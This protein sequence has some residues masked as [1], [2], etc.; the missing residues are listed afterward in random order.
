MMMVI[1]DDGG[2]LCPVAQ[3]SFSTVCHNSAIYRV[4]EGSRADS[5]AVAKEIK[6]SYL[7]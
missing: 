7:D 6:Y 5:E 2:S 3:V 4:E 1:I